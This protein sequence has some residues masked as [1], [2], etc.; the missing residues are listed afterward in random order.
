MRVFFKLLCQICVYVYKVIHKFLE[1]LLA[2]ESY[3]HTYFV[4]WESLCY[5][6][7][8]KNSDVIPLPN[9]VFGFVSSYHSL[10][11]D[12][13]SSESVGALSCHHLKLGERISILSY[14]CIEVSSGSTQLW[15]D[16]KSIGK[17]HYISFLFRFLLG[18]RT[19]A[20]ENCFQLIIGI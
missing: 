10:F 2:S 14:V 16:V 6:K 7:H 8:F 12:K 15:S 13:L 5:F 17:D 19:F 3:C 11:L 1:C 20:W 9:L 4:W 18:F